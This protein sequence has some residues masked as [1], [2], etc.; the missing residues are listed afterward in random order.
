MGTRIL[1][2]YTKQGLLNF[3]WMMWKGF[4][5]WRKKT[6]YTNNVERKQIIYINALYKGGR[7]LK[8][9][10]VVLNVWRVDLGKGSYRKSKGEA[11]VTCRWCILKD[12]L[13]PDE[14]FYHEWMLNYVKCFFWVYWD[15]HVVFIFPFVNVLY[16]IDLHTVSHPCNPGTNPTWSW[17]MILL[18]YCWICL[19]I[20]CWGILHLY[21]LRILACN[22]SL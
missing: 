2:E 20:L 11:E 7:L 14:C 19:L 21:S 12:S 16:H 10:K 4:E 22:F 18:M 8:E 5:I 9:V 1:R 3:S 13:K 15:D 17:C 6:C